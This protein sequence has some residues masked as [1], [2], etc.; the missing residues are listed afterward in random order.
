M[1]MNLTYNLHAPIDVL[2]EIL[3]TLS[4]DLEI[5]EPKR[6]RKEYKRQYRSYNRA[7]PEIRKKY[8]QLRRQID[9]LQ[10]Q[11]DR[12]I[13]IEF[14]R[15]YFDCI[16]NKELK[17][18][19]KKVPINEYVEP[20]VHH[21]LPE[22][23]RLQE[24]LCDFSR[25]ISPSDIVNRRIRIIDLIIAFSYRQEQEV[26]HS[27]HSSRESSEFS[28]E[29]P[30]CEN[31]FPLLYSHLK[32]VPKFQRISYAHPVCQSE[33]LILKHLQHFKNHVQIVHGSESIAS[34]P[35][36]KKLFTTIGEGIAT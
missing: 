13:K 18:Q 19:F 7:P 21:Q 4:S 12:I 33:V 25:D 2:E 27:N 3:K 20:V 24:V 28:E 32:E 9:S 34:T 36:S 22:R 10:K 5:I 15:D 11:Y 35:P 26:Q 29:Q 17:R 1:Y 30:L 16:Y 6:E 31:P 14:W 8:K 23:T